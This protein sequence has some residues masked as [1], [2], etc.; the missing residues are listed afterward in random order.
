MGRCLGGGDLYP[1]REEPG[2]P[3]NI[4]CY[5]STGEIRRH[6]KKKVKKQYR[7][8]QGRDTKTRGGIFLWNGPRA[9]VL[10]D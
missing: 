5:G 2:G 6:W 4:E 10:K 3:K 7:E 8:P 1:R 9:V